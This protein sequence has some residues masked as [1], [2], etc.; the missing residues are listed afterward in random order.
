M[1][2][3]IKAKVKAHALKDNPYEAC[4]YICANYLGEV[5]VVPCENMA[6]NKRGRF[7]VHPKMEAEAEKH[8]QIVA[9]YHS[10]AG[11]F[12]IPE[13]N[14]FSKED[15]DISYEACL[16]ALLYVHPDDTWHY[17]QPDTYEPSDLLGRPFIWGIW[18]CYSLVKDHFKKKKGVKLGTYLPPDNATSLSDFGYERFIANEPFHEVSFEE[19][20]E[21]DVI[22]FK[23]K[24]N[25]CNHSAVYLGNNEFIH[26]PINR[27]SSKG[28][29][30]D[31]HQK[32]IAKILR[33]ND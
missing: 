1:N 21:D 32:H 9:F 16:P 22:I 12:A 6:H 18:D 23:I 31:R 3:E 17:Y 11:E 10:H 24:S 29:L 27:M 20:K 7:S 14:R 13:N 33:L 5:S 8:G 26:Q 19:L 2:A 4:G 30:D 25:F 15:L 28:F